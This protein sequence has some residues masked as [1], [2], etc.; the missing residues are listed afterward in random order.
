[1]HPQVMICKSYP[2]LGAG[3]AAISTHRC[4]NRLQTASLLRAVQASSPSPRILAVPSTS[5]EVLVSFRRFSVSIVMVLVV[6]G[7]ETAGWEPWNHVHALP[8]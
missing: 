8:G 7:V 4:P 6:L 5:Q 2:D 1:M 3:K